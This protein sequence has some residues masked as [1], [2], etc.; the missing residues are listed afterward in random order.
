MPRRTRNPFLVTLAAF[1]AVV[2]CDL[3]GLDLLLAAPFATAQGFA[4]KDAWWLAR[5]RISRASFLEPN[6][7][8]ARFRGR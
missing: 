6:W 1:A 4:L 5:R 7:R 2:A 3:S 8:D